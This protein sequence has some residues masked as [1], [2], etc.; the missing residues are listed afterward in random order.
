MRLLLILLVGL[1]CLDVSAQT[2]VSDSCFVA[3]HKFILLEEDGI[4]KLKAY[5]KG[6]EVP[7]S[8]T[9]K[10]SGPT[11]FVKKN[12][13]NDLLLDDVFTANGDIVKVFLLTGNDAPMCVREDR[14]LKFK[15][16]FCGMTVQGVVISPDGIALTD[17][18]YNGLTCVREH[19]L[20]LKDLL[21]FGTYGIKESD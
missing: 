16:D 1:F 6:N 4:A 13:I 5:Q 3:G 7:V 17:L 20:R 18:V 15:D 19:P 10:M 12:A 9:I 2:R 21:T 11:F 14:N 8:K